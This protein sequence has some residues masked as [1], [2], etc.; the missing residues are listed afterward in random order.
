MTRQELLKSYSNKLDA[1]DKLRG[2]DAWDSAQNSFWY[3]IYQRYCE[4]QKEIW[5]E[6]SNA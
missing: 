5:K 3:K 2:T 6:Q 4:I 1:L